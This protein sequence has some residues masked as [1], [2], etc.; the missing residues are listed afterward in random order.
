MV[1]GEK[2]LRDHYHVNESQNRRNVPLDQAAKQSD[3]LFKK[4]DRVGQS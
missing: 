2:C 4:S 3:I 1:G